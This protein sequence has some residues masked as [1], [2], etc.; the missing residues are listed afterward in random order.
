M[1]AR[2]LTSSRWL[3][4]GLVVGLS[5]VAGTAAEPLWSLKPFRAQPLP[6]VWQKDWPAARADFFILA[7]LEKD[8][9]APNPE[10]DKATLLRRV[11]FDLIGLPPTL[12][13]IAAFES[14]TAPDAYLRVVE[15]LLASPVFGVR[16]GRHWL[17]V[18]RYAET[19][20]NT[21]N[22][23]YPLAWRYRNWVIR[24]F[25]LN[26]P[27]DHFIRQQIAG[28]LLPAPHATAHDDNL[29]ATGFLTIGVKTM[30]EQD[31]VQYELNLADDQI[32]A[33]CRAFLGL[34]ANC[35]RCHDH[36]FDPI[37]TRDYYALAGIFRS[38]R[39]L[40]GVETNSRKEEAEGMALGPDGPTRI[41]AITQHGQKLESMTKEYVEV[42]KKRTSMRDELIKAGLNPAK[43]A[44]KPEM[45][46]D[47]AEKMTSYISLDK[48]VDAWQ[49]KLKAMKES[50]PSPPPTG[51]AA[52]DKPAGT[53]SPLYE[54]GE[55]KKPLAA[56]P[57]GA[58]SC[59]EG[60][61][62]APIGPKESGRRQ[63]ADWIANPQ[64]PL[65]ARVA[66][67]RVWQH[68]YGRGLVATPDD[69]GRMGAKPTHPELLDDL[70]ARFVRDGWDLKGLIRELALS[71][72]YRMSSAPG[73]AK[74]EMVDATNALLHR[75][76]RRQLEAEPMRDAMLVV[77]G[78]LD[79]SPVE[80]SPVA[81]LGEPVKPQGR[82]VGRNGFLNVV[83]ED[84]THR[85]AY[86]PVIRGAVSP[87][88]Q[89]F[90]CADPNFVVGARTASIVPA[91]SLFLM[92][93]DFVLEQSRFLA[94]RL[95]G[96]KSAAP[97]DRIVRLW[98][99]LLTRP[100][101][102]AEIAALRAQLNG[103]PE[104]EETWAQ[105]CQVLMMTGEFRLLY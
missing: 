22:M 43:P 90:D 41:A 73:S 5:T 86:L 32:D 25:N 33:T 8:G 89:C 99:K 20:G 58:L 93:S 66:V 88:M 26:A 84:T 87:A 49:A 4:F 83:P 57:R 74:V 48:E 56:V 9:L 65:T 28:D 29:L 18:A 37:P 105:V 11:F 63:L 92:N 2:V 96:E 36:K 81:K 60:V 39:L 13:D 71:R 27:F 40:S 67:N 59:I 62:L 101:E 95:L 68:L 91:Q 38:T 30:G 34:S 80:G 85:S 104:N 64:N 94:R 52:L 72:A 97:E 1:N 31:L 76:N 61:K 19:S 103:A 77:S 15:R 16:W 51:M 10:A 21:R 50:V 53:D 82:E 3:C 47:V 55:V 23:S 98:R 54:K 45:P 102:P 24:A 17:D 14:D 35:A 78:Q 79:R 12:D 75:M 100:P 69:F 46:K 6:V 42:A 7:R 44:I 70:A